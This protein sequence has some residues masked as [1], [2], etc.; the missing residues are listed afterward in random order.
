MRT[1]S[2]RHTVAGAAGVVL[3]LGLAPIATA[4]AAAPPAP[5]VPPAAPAPGH[6][7]C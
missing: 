4:V 5:P 2:R 6:A 3:A 7:A 1:Q